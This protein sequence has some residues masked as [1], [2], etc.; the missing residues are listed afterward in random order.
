MLP[1][2]IILQEVRKIHERRA[3]KVYYRRKKRLLER[4]DIIVIVGIL[5]T[6]LP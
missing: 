6:A 2:L 4:M 3:K 5:M 1:P